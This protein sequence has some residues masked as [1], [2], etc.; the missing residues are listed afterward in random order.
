MAHRAADRAR[1]RLGAERRHR[2]VRERPRCGFAQAKAETARAAVAAGA[3][4]GGAICR[5]PGLPRLAGAAVLQRGG[6][7]LLPAGARRRALSACNR[8]RGRRRSLVARSRGAE[9]AQPCC[10]Q[11]A[12]TTGRGRFSGARVFHARPTAEPA[13]SAPRRPSTAGRC[14]AWSNAP[15]NSTVRQGV[16]EAPSR[17]IDRGA[18]VAVADRGGHGF[19]A[20]ADL[21]ESGLREAFS[22]ARDLAHAAAGCSL[23]DAAAVAPV[24]RAGRA[25][26]DRRERPV[27]ALRAARADRAAAVGQCRDPPR[28]PHRRLVGE[29]VDGRCR[30]A[31]R[32]RRR[33]R[34]ASAVADADPE[35]PGHRAVRRRDADPLGRRPV[36]RLLPAGRARGARAR[37]AS[38]ADG[39][40]GGARGASSCS[41]APNCPT[42]QAWTCC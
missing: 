3:T 18:M 2:S 12:P 8:S 19:A 16:A 26:P 30:A 5:D 10:V 36:Q 9:T 37:S 1:R 6:A 32:H 31:L 24:A 13:R 23:F 40:R 15:R 11:A 25:M 41:L 22:R 20:T 28:R 35:H 17:R 39:P 27:G 42:R 29:P 33:G 4:D 14:A 21:S 38:T 7:R 34:P